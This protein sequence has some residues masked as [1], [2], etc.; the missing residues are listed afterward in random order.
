MTW[1]PEGGQGRWVCLDAKY[2]TGA[3]NV[4]EAFESAHIYRDAL[5]WQ[6]LGERGRC[7]GAV[8]LVPA[9]DRNTEPWF[10]KAFRDEHGV[11]VFCLTPGQRPPDSLM[12]WFR[13]QLGLRIPD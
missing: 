7:A 12:D 8:L 1:V 3:Q 13:E 2:R 11:G 9:M 10:E 5:R 4:A 6:D